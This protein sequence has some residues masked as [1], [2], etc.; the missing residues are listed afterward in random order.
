MKKIIFVFI[1]FLLCLFLSLGCT[2]SIDEP[3]DDN[4]GEIAVGNEGIIA[5]IFMTN[6]N[7][8]DLV[9]KNVLVKNLDENSLLEE[10]KDC[11]I[12][13]KETNLINFNTYTT[14]D[15]LNVG[16]ANFSKEFYDFNLGSSYE[17]MMLNSVAKTYMDNFKLDK[18]KILVDGNEYQS[19]HIL[20]NEN[21]YFTL[22]SLK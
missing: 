12:V 22:D 7:G 17:S 6:D 10:L 3:S 9:N 19:G 8:D 15:D 11:N 18:F 1:P 5:T 14:D 2:S 4:Y 21:D 13:V 20:F 16:V